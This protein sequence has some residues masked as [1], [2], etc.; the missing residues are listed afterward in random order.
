[1]TG[2][3]ERQSSAACLDLLASLRSELDGFCGGEPPADD[4]TC[5]ALRI[6]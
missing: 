1:M 5:I 6:E 2:V 4:L 3:L